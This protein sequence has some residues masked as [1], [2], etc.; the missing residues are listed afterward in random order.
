M[1]FLL[2]YL[3]D[4]DIDSDL[5][6]FEDVGDGDDVSF[7][8]QLFVLEVSGCNFVFISLQIPFCTK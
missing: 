2:Q 6:N 8:I 1:Q 7:L 5:D 4:L 3:Q